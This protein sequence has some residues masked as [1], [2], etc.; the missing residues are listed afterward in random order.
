MVR[1]Q[2]RSQ[3]WGSR[4]PVLHSEASYL[5]SI[6]GKL[7]RGE[8]VIGGASQEAGVLLLA[9]PLSNPMTESFSCFYK[10]IWFY[11]LF[12]VFIFY[13]L[14]KKTNYLFSLYIPIQIPTPLILST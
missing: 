1:L 3:G 5:H 10:I 13:F 9:V 4:Y 12:F 8:W 2:G 14:K 7:G 11:F 6:E